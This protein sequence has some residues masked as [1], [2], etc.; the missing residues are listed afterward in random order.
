MGAG[1]CD[2]CEVARAFTERE[3]AARLG[4]SAVTLRAW[5]H[6]G[7]GPAFVRLGRAVRYLKTDL[8]NFLLTC[9]SDDAKLS[10]PATGGTP[11]QDPT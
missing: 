8:D 4:I 10:A 6:R 11:D 1:S 3:V 9:R 7:I 2:R 5:R